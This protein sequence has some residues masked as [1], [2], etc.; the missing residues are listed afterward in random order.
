MAS[1]IFTMATYATARECTVKNIIAT[2][3]IRNSYG[4]IQSFKFSLL[5]VVCKVITLNPLCIL[6]GISSLLLFDGSF[7]KLFLCHPSRYREAIQK[8][9]HEPI[10]KTWNKEIKSDNSCYRKVGRLITKWGA[11][12]KSPILLSQSENYF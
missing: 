2:P 11:I 8:R 4:A 1:T 6:F 7:L 12:E 9:S 5:I 10:Y 3:K